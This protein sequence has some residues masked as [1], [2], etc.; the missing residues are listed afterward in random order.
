AT[1]VPMLRERIKINMR[2]RHVDFFDYD[3]E[4]YEAQPLYWKS[5]LIDDSFEDFSR[6]VSFDRRLRQLGVPGLDEG[7]GPSF[8]L[9]SN[10]L[11][12]QHGLRMQG[13][14]FHKL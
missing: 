6:Q 14:R 8:D 10:T 11:A 5:R 13:Y 9:F 12:E 4:E 1:P 7:Y 3:G 2:N